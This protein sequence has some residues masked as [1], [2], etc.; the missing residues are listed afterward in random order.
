[1]FLQKSFG[2]FNPLPDIC[3][4]EILAVFGL[5]T[6]AAVV[7]SGGGATGIGALY[8]ASTH[9]VC[10]WLLVLRVLMLML[11][12][13]LVLLV[14]RGIGFGISGHVARGK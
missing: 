8:L 12:N 3:Y 10:G 6:A 4:Y 11:V 14:S 2:I 9:F 1:M 7:G 13:L 5:L